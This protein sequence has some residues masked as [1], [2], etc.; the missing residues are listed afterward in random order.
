MGLQLSI[1]TPE[2]E[3]FAGEVDSLLA[4]GKDGEMGVLPHHAPLIAVLKEGVLIA[5]QGEEELVFAVHGGY[6]QVLPDRV[7]VLA[8]V[9]ERAEEI[10]V[11]RAE[12]ARRRAEELLKKEP[13]PEVRAEA[14]AALRRSLVR[15]RVAR[16]RRYRIESERPEPS[17]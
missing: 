17:D 15:L 16:R 12:A 7:I 14:A 2:R 9:A 4:P 5:R 10:D 1:V 11:E 8:D 6:M 13:P 3:L